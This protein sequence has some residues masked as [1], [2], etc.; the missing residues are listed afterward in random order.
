MVYGF[1]NIYESSNQHYNRMQGWAIKQSA[2]T[3]I[4]KAYVNSVVE[5]GSNDCPTPC[6]VSTSHRERVA[7][8]WLSVSAQKA[9]VGIC[10]QC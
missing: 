9:F 1:W 10:G 6:P 7:S 3:C 8:Y 4:N 5:A 2:I